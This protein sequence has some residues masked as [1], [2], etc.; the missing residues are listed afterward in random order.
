MPEF[1]PQ[2]KIA[3]S[4]AEG[5]SFAAVLV[6]TAPIVDRRRLGN[7]HRGEAAGT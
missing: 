4:T 3:S 5:G 1:A 7:P 6:P 2:S